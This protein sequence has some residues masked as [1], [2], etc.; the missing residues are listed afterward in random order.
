MGW[1]SGPMQ[2]GQWVGPPVRCRA[3]SRAA[4]PR[5]SYED[6]PEYRDTNRP[7]RERNETRF[8]QDIAPRQDA[9]EPRAGCATHRCKVESGLDVSSDAGRRPAPHCPAQVTRIVP[10]RERR[11]DHIAGGTVRVSLRPS[12]PGRMPGSLA[13]DARPTV[14]DPPWVGRL[15]RCRAASRAALPRAS[16]DNGPE[17]R[18]T[19]RPHRGRNGTRFVE[20]IAPRQD[21]GEPRAGCATHDARPTVRDPQWATHFAQIAQVNTPPAPC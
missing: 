11:T 20:D 8:V 12:L 3:A 7:H 21:A 9:G 10:S 19:N 2:G 14:R 18:D 17:Y 13:Q 4:L 1:T 6:G 15:V 5:A 16:Y